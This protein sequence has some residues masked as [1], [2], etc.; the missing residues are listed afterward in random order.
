[1]HGELRAC[2]WIFCCTHFSVSKQ[3]TVQINQARANNS[4][5]RE[6]VTLRAKM[7]ECE[8]LSKS[9]K[10]RQEAAE[11]THKDALKQVYQNMAAL[12]ENYSRYST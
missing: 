6:P 10:V 2:F 9:A 12:Q 1:M 8:R 5:N 11:G 3:N 7:E 4:C